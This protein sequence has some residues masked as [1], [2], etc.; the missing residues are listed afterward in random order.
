MIFFSPKIRY[1]ETFLELRYSSEYLAILIVRKSIERQIR[2][3][4]QKPFRISAVNVTK[5]TAD[6]VTLTEE[7]PNGKLHFLYSGHVRKY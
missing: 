3:T 5:S 7:I 1:T 2:S 6:L 4:A